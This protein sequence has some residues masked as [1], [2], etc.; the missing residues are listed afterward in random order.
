MVIDLIFVV[1]NHAWL[2]YL[3]SSVCTVAIFAALD[4]EQKIM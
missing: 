2:L 4:G 1:L 3:I